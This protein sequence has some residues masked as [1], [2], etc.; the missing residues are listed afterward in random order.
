[1]LSS[2]MSSKQRDFNFQDCIICTKNEKINP[3]FWQQKAGLFFLFLH[4]IANA[5]DSFDIAC[6]PSNVNLTT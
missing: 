1:M 3:P 4:S 5:T 2:A 6:L